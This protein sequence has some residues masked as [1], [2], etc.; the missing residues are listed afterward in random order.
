MPVPEIAVPDTLRELTAPAVN[1]PPL[2]DPPDTLPPLSD[3][4]E[5]VAVLNVVDVMVAPLYVPPVT[6]PLAAMVVA[7]EIAPVLVMP[8]VL[9]LMPPE[10]EAPPLAVTR[11]VKVGALTTEREPQDPPEPRKNELPPPVMLVPLEGQVMGVLPATAVL[12]IE[13]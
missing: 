7:P 10:T 3:P 5:I 1:V 12:A 6:A 4:P 13:P 2:T 9:L 8:P 11:P